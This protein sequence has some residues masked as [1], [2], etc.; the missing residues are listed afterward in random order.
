MCLEVPTRGAHIAFPSPQL[1]FAFILHRFNVVKV[2]VVISALLLSRQLQVFEIRLCV[3]SIWF[4]T[5]RG[6]R[7]FE[8]RWAQC[9]LA[10]LLVFVFEFSCVV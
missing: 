3:I 7:G 9:F 2:A 5:V 6:I 1:S 8:L 4:L 10:N